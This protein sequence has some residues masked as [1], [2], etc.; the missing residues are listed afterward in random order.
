MLAQA[1]FKH[2]LCKALAVT[3]CHTMGCTACLTVNYQ[4]L[5]TPAC[6]SCSRYDYEEC[7]SESAGKLMDHLRG[8]IAS[9]PPGTKFG[10]FELDKADDFCYTDPIDGSVAKGQVGEGLGRCS[11]HCEGTPAKQCLL[12]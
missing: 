9:S 12:G 5:T 3:T 2:M 4:Q 6:L 1:A 10:A 7:D 11:F 8:V